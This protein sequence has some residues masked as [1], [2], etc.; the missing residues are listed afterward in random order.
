MSNTKHTP[1]PWICA[2]EFIG[3]KN[4][5]P[6]TIAY[7]SNHRNGVRRSG[8]ENKANAR[9]IAAAPDLLALL[10]KVD[11]LLAEWKNLNYI[12]YGKMQSRFDE[13]LERVE[14]EIEEAIAA[15]KGE[16]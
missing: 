11:S 4:G 16:A 3:T 9:L 1:G 10:E 7:T 15:A 12:N 8:Q 2:G 6:Q 13:D 5:E 14:L